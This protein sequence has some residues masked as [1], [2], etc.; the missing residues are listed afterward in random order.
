MSSISS[1]L[2]KHSFTHLRAI[3]RSPL[4]ILL[5]NQV[6]RSHT[7]AHLSFK[8]FTRSTMPAFYCLI[9]VPEDYDVF[10]QI[11]S[12]PYARLSSFIFCGTPP[13]IRVFPGSVHCLF[14][15]KQF[16][17]QSWLLLHFTTPC[18]E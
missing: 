5:F 13:K 11:K 12:V 16:I 8:T 6:L 3:D 1:V 2:I 4:F 9:C 7:D 18:T 15:C 17:L 10:L 14:N